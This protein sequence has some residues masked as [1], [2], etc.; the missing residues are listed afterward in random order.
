MDMIDLGQVVLARRKKLKMSQFALASANGMSRATISSLENGKLPEL[1]IRKVLAICA[2]LGLELE[3]KEAS[4][5]PT[6]RDLVREKT[7]A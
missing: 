3:L 1:G 5:R 7:R 6:L 4:L 2:T